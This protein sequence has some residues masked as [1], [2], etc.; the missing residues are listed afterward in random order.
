MTII[1]V[2]IIVLTAVVILAVA[3]IAGCA[4]ATR[5]PFRWRFLWRRSRATVAA[6]YVA[7]VERC[8]MEPNVA[9]EAYRDEVG[10]MHVR[11]GLQVID[12][13]YRPELRRLAM[14]SERL[15]IKAGL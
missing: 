5:K 10:C 14:E 3:D 11:D 1:G 15:R 6:K 9:W 8:E 13:I 7:M 12:A 2:V 4:S